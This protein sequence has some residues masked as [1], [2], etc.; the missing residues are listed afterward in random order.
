MAGPMAKFVNSV[1][2]CKN[3]ESNWTRILLMMYI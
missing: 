3:I 1:L 2:A